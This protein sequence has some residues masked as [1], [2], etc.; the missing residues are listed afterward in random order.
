M[1]TPGTK[2]VL[3]LITKSN[4]G[5]AQRYVYDLA[6][7]LDRTQFDVVVAMGGDGVL[8]EMLQN[9][10]I[11]T[12]TVPSLT[13]TMKPRA[14]IIILKELYA[15]LRTESPAVLHLNSSVAGFLGTVAG[16]FA[17]VPK[18]IFTAHG[19]AFNEDRPWWQKQLI[20]AFHWST[21]LCSHHTIAVSNG[22]AKQ[23]NWPLP[24]NR[25][26]VINPGRTIGAMFPKAEARAKLVDFSPELGAYA[27]DPWVLCIAELHPIKR[28]DILFTAI[29]SLT[30]VHP[31]LRL[32]CIGDGARRAY[33]AHLIKKHGMRDHIFL[34][35]SVHEAARFLHAAD[36][37]VLSSTSESYGYVIHEAGLANV[38]VVAT[39]VGGITDII[40][41]HESGWLV[42]PNDVAD[43]AGAIHEVLTSPEEVLTRTQN[44]KN[45]LAKRTT[46]A[47]ATETAD[48]YIS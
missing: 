1:T 27:K 9:A 33:L 29:R 11:R 41:D 23:M 28:H 22:M 42:I 24:K 34:L 48:L 47:M 18:I 43:L 14:A 4:W 10:G 44:L 6:T 26:S 12:I 35:G 40:T 37:F 17:R 38:P 32:I 21:V 3:F 25:L 45:K 5:G 46:A 31:K 15:L 36:V 39:H 20:K 30:A 19:W 16:R 13:N 7:N 2:K 8:R